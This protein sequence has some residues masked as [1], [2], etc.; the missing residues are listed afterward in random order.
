M[1]SLELR[2]L[3]RLHQID[4]SLVEI[5]KRAAALDPG[6]ALQAQMEILKAEHAEKLA[7]EKAVS[8]EMTDLELQQKTLS[9]KIKKFDKELFG[10]K[11][12]NPR[13]VETIEKEIESLKRRRS[14]LE[15]EWLVASERIK[16]AS[17]AVKEVDIRLSA[18][19]AQDKTHQ[20]KA[21][22]LKAQ[23]ESEFKRFTEARPAALKE[24][25][26]ALLAKYDALR[27]RLGGVAMSEAKNST[28]SACGNTL[29]T[30]TM[31]LLREDR[32]VSCEQ[33]HRILYYTEGVL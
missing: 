30:R 4:A 25:D 16:P 19:R 10:G 24:V 11:V 33:C 14:D 31:T 22:D 12:V 2:K 20:S 26:P 7:Q 32:V 29:P 21:M 1:S 17:D 15:T 6:R 9:D 28:C 5:R 23:L 18:L 8:G 27:A 13:E 3:W